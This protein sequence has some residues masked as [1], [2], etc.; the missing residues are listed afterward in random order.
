MT[1][2]VVLSG[3][4]LKGRYRLHDR[5][6]GGG[7]GEV[8]RATD[9][10][11][12]RPVAVKLLQPGYAGGEDDLA[13][14]RAEARHAGSLSHPGIAH[15]YDYGDADPAYP[16]Y[17]VMELVGGPSL[18][19]L[20]D[21]GPLD[22]ARTMALIAQVAGALQAAHAAGLVHR[23]I[24]AGNVLVSPGGQVKITDFRDRACGGIRAGDP[25]G[26]ADR[27]AGVPGAGA[28]RGWAGYARGR[29]VRAG[30][31]GL[32]VPDRQ[33]PV[34]RGTPGGRPGASGAAAAR[35][36]R[37]GCLSRLPRWSPT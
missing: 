10:V 25:P 31:R 12:E 2:I 22:P 14:F 15:V 9:L 28:G 20:L 4:L 26:G 24:K 29:P 27:H 7:M 8:W 3:L 21:D 5:I 13:R 18:A 30:H 37:P 17:L 36:C 16:P 19:S 35:R 1:A 33:A 32:P 23:D 11:L 34:Q 6:G